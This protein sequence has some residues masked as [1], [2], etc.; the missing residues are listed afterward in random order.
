M[1]VVGVDVRVSVRCGLE[2]WDSGV[3]FGI[4]VRG[5]VKNGFGVGLGR[6]DRVEVGLGLGVWSWLGIGA[7]GSFW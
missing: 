5:N 2:R 3:R 1:I 7:C 6:G 4:R